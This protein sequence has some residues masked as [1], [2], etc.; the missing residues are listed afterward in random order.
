MTWSGS[1]TYGG[2]TLSEEI[3]NAIV[4]RSKQFNVLPTGVICQMYLESHW[5]NSG[6]GANPA[7]ANWSG[8]TY[9][10]PYPG[11]FGGVVYYEKGTARPASEGLYY[12]KFNNLSDFFMAHCWL[13]GTGS[14]IYKSAGKTTVKG[15]GEG[16]FI[17]GG[18]K[19]NYASDYEYYVDTLLSIERGIKNSYPNFDEIN[20]LAG[21]IT[22]DSEYLEIPAKGATESNVTSRWGWRVHPITG[23]QDFHNALDIAMAMGTPIVATL[24]GVVKS[25]Q[26]PYPNQDYGGTGYGNWLEIEHSNGYSSRYAH[27]RQII[28]TTG[29]KVNKGDVI[30]YM[31][32][33]GSSTGSHL[34]FELRHIGASDE[35]G[36][37]TVDPYPYLFENVPIYGTEGGSTGEQDDKF[38]WWI[39]LDFY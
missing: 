17:S 21:M 33:T 4:Y 30:G 20:L 24:G 9:F 31:G 15:F 29:Q 18:A 13:V 19:Y 2:N 38:K 10:S 32:S 36:T 27:L 11:Q 16:L 23:E 3:I 39:Y 12:V 7:L 5:G 34:H 22:G 6:A 14:G 37:N 35:G 28:V 1:I 26:Q 25:I 8:I